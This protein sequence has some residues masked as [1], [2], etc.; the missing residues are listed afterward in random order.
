MNHSYIVFATTIFLNSF[1]KYFH[2]I[3]IFSKGGYG[4]ECYSDGL[5]NL[6]LVDY[7]SGQTSFFDGTPDDDGSDDGLGGCK[8]VSL[9]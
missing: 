1:C 2:H 9:E 6:E 5:D 4:S 3:Q 7:K 8:G